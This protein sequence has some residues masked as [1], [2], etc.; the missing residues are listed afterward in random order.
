MTPKTINVGGQAVIEGVMMRSP[1]ALAIAVRIP[2]G[3]ITVKT[4]KLKDLASRPKILQLPVIRGVVTL[5]QA[6]TLGIQALNFSANQSLE[7]EEGELGAGVLT[8]TIGF[9]FVLGIALFVYLPLFL[10]N[11]LKD[12]LPLVATSTVLFNLIDGLLRVMIFLAYLI[13]ISQI[14]DLRRV[15][16]YHGAEHKTIYTYENGEDLTVEQAQRYSTLHPRCG[17]NFLLIVMLMSILVF[18]ILRSDAPFY[19]KFASRLVF[20]PLIAGISYEIIR[21]AGKHQD[22]TWVRWLTKPGLSLQKI[23]TKPPSA[24]QLEVAIRALQEVLQMEKD[25]PDSTRNAMEVVL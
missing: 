2:S 5:F 16:E 1:A 22:K 21:F 3:E 25:R 17:T 12:V 18:S 24:D 11:L 15:F 8:L 23:T 19:I 6:L 4:Q 10:T 7:E 13:G 20:V 9:A 14:K